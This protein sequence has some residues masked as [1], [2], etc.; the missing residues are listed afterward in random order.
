LRMPAS[1]RRGGAAAKAGAVVAVMAV[2]GMQ[3]NA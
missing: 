3:K 1:C 2:D